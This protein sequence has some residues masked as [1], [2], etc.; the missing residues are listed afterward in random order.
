MSDL[1][2]NGETESQ[3][4]QTTVEEGTKFKGTLESSCQVLVRGSVDGDLIAPSLVVS[5]SGTVVGNIRAHSIQS[6]GVLAG[7]IDADEIQLSGSVRSDTVIRAKTL[8]VR[9]QSSHK[10]LEITFGECV[11][12]VGDDP[13]HFLEVVSPPAMLPGA[14]SK[15]SRRSEAAAVEAPEEKLKPNDGSV[16]VPS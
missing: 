15:K 8:E 1:H 12:D 9:L 10:K 7:Y 2:A 16:P 5:A 4:K 11:L 6:Q 3:F 13:A 14:A